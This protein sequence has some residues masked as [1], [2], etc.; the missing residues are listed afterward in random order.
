MANKDGQ[1]RNGKYGIKQGEKTREERREKREERREKGGECPRRTPLPSLKRTVAGPPI[2]YTHNIFSYLSRVF[3]CYL[4][5]DRIIILS[6][7]RGM[8]NVGSLREGASVRRQRT[9]MFGQ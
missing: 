7:C 6:P 8:A 3:L 4:F 5:F 9:R 1:G 2:F